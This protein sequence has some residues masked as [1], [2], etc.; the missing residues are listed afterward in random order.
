MGAKPEDVRRWTFALRRPETAVAAAGALRGSTGRAEVEAL[1]EVVEESPSAAAVVAAVAALEGC[2]APVVLQALARA[3]HHPR[4]LVRCAAVASLG[5]RVAVAVA[6]AEKAA[7]ARRLRE[8]PAWT[9]RRAA[10]R[11]LEDLPP[12]DDWLILAAADDP[13]WRVRHALIRV[14]SR[15]GMDPS[16]RASID[17][18]LAVAAQDART[19]GVRDY[20]RFRWHGDEPPPRPGPSADDPG[21]PCP[22]QDDDPA[23]L[24][25]DLERSGVEG[26]RRAVDRMPR[27]LGHD[28]ERVR[29]RAFETLQ[30]AGELPQLA[31]AVRLL[32]EPRRE[33]AGLVRELLDGL[34]LDRAEALAVHVLNAPDPSPATLA[35]ALDQVGVSLP[36][37][38]APTAWL[39]LTERADD[40][41]GAVR[42]A[43]AGL[44]ARRGQ[45]SDLDRLRRFLDDPDPAVRLVALGAIL[46]GGAPL[47]PGRVE[48]L[49][50]DP[51]PGVRARLARWLAG[52][53]EPAA[54]PWVARLQDDPHP[55]VRAAALTRERADALIRDPARET[56]W[57]VLAG[58]ARLRKVPFRRLAPVPAWRPD[59]VPQHVEAPLHPR[60]GA[61]PGPNARRLGRD[62]PRV[63]PVGVSGH[64]GLP[65]EGFVRAIEAGVNLMFWE[66]SYQTMTRFFARLPPVDRASIHLIA[67]TFEADGGRVRRDAE[68]AL[69]ALGV[70]R[71]GVF[72]V[73][74]VRSWSRVPDEVTEVLRS[75]RDA[76]TVAAF[77]LSTHSRAFAVEALGAG[78][79]PL[80]VRHSAAHRGAEAVVF[81]TAQA[82]G[83]GVV[84]FNNTC[85][86][87]L[88]A[89]PDGL[90]PP[91]R[92]ADC[93]RYSLAQP[94]VAACLTAPATLDELDAN[95]EALRHP[96]LPP[97]R[98]AA[99]RA[100]GDSV[101]REDSVFRRLVRSV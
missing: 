87:R 57:L 74:W 34:D 96:E 64:Y 17:E 81:P 21:P 49:A 66:P 99:L 95:L 16:D 43:L 25:R 2:D 1:A 12:P 78:W 41:P 27:L 91:H 55:R 92:A 48:R 82:R 38:E 18:R 85:Y 42:L 33:A 11:A 59:P 7:L 5:R 70:E 76:G 83:T 19:Q 86:G 90:I 51:D 15:R 14:L 84:T 9:C 67:G 31:E 37:E 89:G 32:D 39:D 98:A 58:A 88:L 40:K 30:A 94:G 61:G 63:A 50:G 24:A 75:L 45:P 47:D 44:A 65:V 3:L 10:L 6:V 101:Y 100:A 69:R 28:D 29:R 62:G 97:E 26:R 79:D 71:L 8:D 93:Y 56:S 23:V 73:F 68:R 72:L 80:M 22:F 60:P 77:G 46:E 35:W 4:P 20:L 13:H 36:I 54:A 53:P 52:R